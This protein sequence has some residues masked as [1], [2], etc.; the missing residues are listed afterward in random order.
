[1]ENWL[2]SEKEK[3]IDSDWLCQN[4]ENLL[5]NVDK[6]LKTKD[7]KI[8]SRVCSKLSNLYKDK[9][10]RHQSLIVNCIPVLLNYY[11]VFYYDEKISSIIE[12]CI[13]TIYNLSLSDE[14]VKLNR[15]R[16]PNLSTPSSYH[17]PQ[18]SSIQFELSE[19][20]MS[21]Y[22]SEY[23]I[24]EEQFKPFQDKITREKRFQ[25]IKFLL[26]LYY[27][28]LVAVIKASKLY[29]CDMCLKICKANRLNVPN[30]AI[31]LNSD[32]LNEMLRALFY[33][34]NNNMQ[35]DAYIA[36][37]AIALKAEE[38][39]MVDVILMSNSIK[40][41]IQ[42]SKNEPQLQN[43]TN[44][45]DMA[46]P[47]EHGNVKTS[48]SGSVS[49]GRKKSSDN[50]SPSHR[51]NASPTASPKSGLYKFHENEGKNSFN[52]IY[53]SPSGEIRNAAKRASIKIQQQ[54]Q[55]VLLQQLHYAELLENTSSVPPP[56]P[57]SPLPS[58]NS[59]NELSTSAVAD[60]IIP[61]IDEPNGDAK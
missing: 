30:Q 53:V 47:V 19:S 26:L 41:L 27:S 12:V 24:Q 35:L 55:N 16:I 4:A 38:E 10:Q 23:V 34:F 9:E 42:Q 45:S 18:V 11:F 57:T 43:A 5:E 54:Q 37:E 17:S 48:R 14:N 8:V 31:Y 32:I 33:L 52:E 36:I 3:S 61:I 21:K 2:L 29:F 56:I 49:V 39:L 22:E 7:E 40:N 50:S 58:A 46:T 1:M 59:E 44:G 25:I 15:I 13:L 51:N 6:L 60:K 20:A 28:R